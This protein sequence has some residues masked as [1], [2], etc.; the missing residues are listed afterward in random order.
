[1]NLT[2]CRRGGGGSVSWFIVH[3]F[4]TYIHSSLHSFL[5]LA[6]LTLFSVFQVVYYWYVHLPVA[7]LPRLL[8]LSSPCLVLPV[9]V[10]MGDR[11][12]GRDAEWQSGWPLDVVWLRWACSVYGFPRR[13]LQAGGKASPSPTQI[14]AQHAGGGIRTAAPVGVQ[15]VLGLL[16]RTKGKKE[17]YTFWWDFRYLDP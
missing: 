6:K 11:N 2:Q 5:L 7:I 8:C 13:D 16:Q 12:S 14:R 17:A 3:W 15:S 1:M 9:W 10:S 4:S